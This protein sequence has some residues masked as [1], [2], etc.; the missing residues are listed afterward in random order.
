MV[1]VPPQLNALIHQHF[2]NVRLD[3]DVD[4]KN[5]VLR[6]EYHRPRS[7]PIRDT[8]ASSRPASTKRV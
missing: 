5:S 6:G 7:N 3:M 1:H 8:Y 2:F 4:G